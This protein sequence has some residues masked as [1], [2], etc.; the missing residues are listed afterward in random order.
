MPLPR[1]SHQFLFLAFDV[2][3][4]LLDFNG[5]RNWC[6]LLSIIMPTFQFLDFAVKVVSLYFFGI[7]GVNDGS[8][9]CIYPNVVL[10]IVYQ[11][12]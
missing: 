4:A 9:I 8:Y 2:E 1:F 11:S 6:L 10:N 3:F 5:S 7:L 12:W